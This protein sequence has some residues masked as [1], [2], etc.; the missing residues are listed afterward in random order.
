MRWY[1]DN[2]ELTGIRD[3]EIPDVLLFGGIV[4]DAGAEA[5]LRDAVE[6]A[7]AAALGHRRVPIKWNVKDLR[8]LYEKQKKPDIYERLLKESKEIRTAVLRAAAKVDFSI[9]ISCLQS[10]SIRRE[11]IKDK[12]QLLAAMVFANGLMRLS[13]HA[14]ERRP[15]VVQVVLDW[16]DRAD[17]QPFDKEYATAF[18]SGQSRDAGVT[19]YSGPLKDLGFLDSVAYCNMHHSTLL[20]L[21]DLVLGATRDLIECALGKKTDALGLTLLPDLRPHF[22]G[23]PDRVIG[24]GINLSGDDQFKAKIAEFWRARDAGGVGAG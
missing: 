23:A 13:M 14:K 9:A 22:L 11:V 16:P 15:S 8:S 19:Y 1:G 6:S 5:P 21:S 12:K 3:A 18:L 17:S 24:R 20:Q 2:S 7:K 10:H 4:V